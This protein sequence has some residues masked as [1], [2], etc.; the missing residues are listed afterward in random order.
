MFRRLPFV[1]AKTPVTV[2]APTAIRS[3]W[4][5]ASLS[6]YLVAVILAATVPLALLSAWQIIDDEHK[7][8]ETLRGSLRGLAKAVSAGVDRELLAA[9]D[10]LDA[11]A[12]P[13]GPQGVDLDTIERRLRT[14]GTLPPAW[15]RV[16]LLAPDG[17]MRF[18]VDGR[19]AKGREGASSWPLAPPPTSAAEREALVQAWRAAP[20]DRPVLLSRLDVDPPARSTWVGRPLATPDGTR[21]L[22]AA[23]SGPD[24]WQSLLQDASLDTDLFVTLFDAQHRVIARTPEVERAIG[25]VLRPQAVAA[26]ADAASGVHQ[27]ALL[28]G[29]ASHTAWQ[30]LRHGGWGVG[31]GA[32]SARFDAAQER[33]ML[34][35]FATAAGCLLLGV[36]AALAVARHVARPLR[37][38]IRSGTGSRADADDETPIDVA[39][40]AQLRD[41]LA[42]VERERN[43]AA[44]RLA[45]KAGEAEAANRA[46]DELLGMLGHELRNPLNA[47]VT[48]V[49]VLRRAAPDSDLATSARAVIARQ[50]RKLAAML[51]EL[52]DVGQVMADEVTLALQPVDLAEL[53]RGAVAGAQASADQ[54]QQQLVVGELA[55]LCVRGDARRLTQVLGHLLDN[56]MK[57]TP[58]GST[59]RVELLHEA[60]AALLRVQDTGPGIEPDLLPRIFEPF[61]QGERGLDRPAGGLG[62]GLALVKR[63]VELH[64][65]TVRAGTSAH[66]SG[67]EV[68]LPTLRPALDAARTAATGSSRVGVIDDNPDVLT[69][70]RSMLELAG[71]SVHTA[72]DGDAGLAMLLADAPDVAIVDIGLPGI[73][74]YEVARRSRAAG[75]RGRLIALSGYGQLRDL[76]RS[77][78]E[79]FDAHLVK[80]V[81][82]DQLLPL[83]SAAA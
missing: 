65:G 38:L 44:E 1:L 40:I 76:Q 77:V 33:A 13:S 53:A 64:G 3:R 68:R 79:G 6:T 73:D 50:T 22:L 56:A 43:E 39:E 37:R 35:A 19:V 75:Y 28:D 16:A 5:R 41:A 60:G 80:P 69:S 15:P 83:L 71:H 66:G 36:S 74:G 27:A 54:R 30:R 2:P 42:L 23:R 61:V 45:R 21:Y 18:E 12:R 72:A 34:L 81:N 29:G 26:M 10:A 63:L 17:S 31:V 47:I 4:P 14:G 11:L 52:L 58:A 55:A 8:R 82:P 9:V 59:I 62:L 70:M 25:T 51:D 78:S 57:Y 7:Q 67:F 32:S 20:G 46:K 48:A 24:L 49:E